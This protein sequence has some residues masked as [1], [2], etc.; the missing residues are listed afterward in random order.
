VA[1][2]VRGRSTSIVDIDLATGAKRT[3]RRGTK[4]QVSQPAVLGRGLL[5]VAVSR[6]K[7]ELR[8]AG[9]TK[10]ERVLLRRRPAAVRDRGHDPGHTTQGER[11]P[12]KR[13]LARPGS[14]LIWSTALGF[15][16]AYVTILRSRAD[17]TTAQRL[18]AVPR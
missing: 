15:D 7:Q 1:G 5:Y 6:C 8:L 18:L 9:T 10:K 4:V 12:C 14:D 3:L 11:V 2:V 13:A 17:G 16:Q